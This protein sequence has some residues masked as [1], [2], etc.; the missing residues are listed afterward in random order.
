[1]STV[2]CRSFLFSQPG[3]I[4]LVY[5][6]AFLLLAT[7]ISSERNKCQCPDGC[8]NISKTQRRSAGLAGGAVSGQNREGGRL[9]LRR[10]PRDNG[11]GISVSSRGDG[12]Q[13][14]IMAIR[15]SE[16][17]KGSCVF[18][19]SVGV[20]GVR[21]ADRRPASQER[22]SVAQS[23]LHS[24]S[25]NEA[26]HFSFPQWRWHAQT[27]ARSPHKPGSAASQLWRSQRGHG[28]GGSFGT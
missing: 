21:H 16:C 11:G 25:Y 28:I 22:L 3:D 5:A 6:H 17:W 7:T 8:P 9:A 26:L 13:R 18:A 27:A 23:A 2:S 15:R 4:P 14:L 10:S 24:E 20:G 12:G 19:A 1:L